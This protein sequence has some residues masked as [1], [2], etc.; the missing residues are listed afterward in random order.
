MPWCQASFHHMPPLPAP[1]LAASTPTD[2]ALL[3]SLP[4]SKKLDS[5]APGGGAGCP[6]ACLGLQKGGDPGGHLLGQGTRKPHGNHT[7]S[8]RASHASSPQ[9]PPEL[10]KPLHSPP[11]GREKTEGQ[12]RRGTGGILLEP[13]PHYPWTGRRRG[14]EST[15]YCHWESS[16]PTPPHPQAFSQNCSRP[17]PGVSLSTSSSP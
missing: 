11:L 8:P 7:S 16:V 13:S 14:R 3:S 15:R 5:S 4:I 10:P 17:R 12:E 6:T 1:G 9:D 2:P